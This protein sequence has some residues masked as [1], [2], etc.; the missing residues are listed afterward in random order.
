MSFKSC[1]DE[2]SAR[3][4]GD[5]QRRDFVVIDISA[6]LR[7]TNCIFS[8]PMLCALLNFAL[9]TT[10]NLEP[11]VIK[12]VVGPERL[13]WIFFLVHGHACMSVYLA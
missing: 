2:I 9:F 5:C 4:G 13:K 1:T 6:F 11:R 7:S 12:R 3:G 8:S 10:E